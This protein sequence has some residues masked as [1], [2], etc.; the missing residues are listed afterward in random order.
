MRANDD[1]TY[2]DWYDPATKT[3][4]RDERQTGTPYYDWDT[5][6]SGT[7]VG[8]ALL[9]LTQ[10]TPTFEVGLDPAGGDIDYTGVWFRATTAIPYTPKPVEVKGKTVTETI[11]YKYQDGQMAKPDVVKHVTLGHQVIKDPVTGEVT[12]DH[13]ETKSFDKVSSP[14]VAGYTP[15]QENIGEVTVDHNSQNIEKTVIYTKNPTKPVRQSKTVTEVIHYQ[16]KDG[17]QAHD[18]YVAVPKTFTRTGEQDVITGKVTWGAWTPAQQFAQAK[19]P[20]IHGYTPDHAQ[21]DKITVDHNSQ[22]VE[23]TV[24]YTKKPA[25]VVHDPAT[26][27]ERIHY[28]YADGRQA[29]PDYEKTLSFTVDGTQDP[30]TGQI[31]WGAWSPAQEFASVKSPEIHGYTPDREVIGGVSVDHN[32]QNIEKTVVYTK[33]APTVVKQSKTV[34]EIVHY[35][36]ENGS[37][38]H[39]DYIATPNTFTRT[40]EKDAVT[41]QITWGSWTPTQ[42][43]AQVKSPEIHGY[44]PA[45]EVIGGVS[46]NYNSQNIEKTVVYTKKA[47]TAVSQS[48][49]VKEIIHYQFEDGRQAHDD[50]VAVPK[51][52]TRTGEQ[53]AVTGQ[54][55]W[56][57]WTPAQ[58][59]SSVKSPEI[60]GYAPDQVQIGKI[61][62]DHNG[63]NVEK[64]VV[65][66]KNAPT[67]DVPVRDNHQPG[68]TT[69]NKP[70]EPAK[71][72]NKAVWP[73]Q[74]RHS[75]H[76]QLPQTGNESNHSQLVVGLLEVFSALGF[77]FRKRSK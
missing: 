30:V 35:R 9:E 48:K 54:I 63:K 33:N 56:G 49:T 70:S 39:D 68:I 19:S 7:Y 1:I 36:F 17:R 34:T 27:T 51:T 14:T 65:Y 22:N 44:T 58:D 4:H 15:D 13:W 66:T 76:T 5:H 41:G 18:D 61:T 71:L 8:S 55:T 46:V 57:N 10:S 23:K 6:A 11:H 52:F 50:Y 2:I 73:I 64:T 32:S 67:T 40:G 38:A 77:L 20:E 28:V 72:T 12:W 26:V 47:P 45:K 37:Q 31:T 43:F 29:A 60:H 3:V 62:V 24:T 59:F 42:Q 75:S 16:Y 21:I 69:P 74:E 25:I 53:D